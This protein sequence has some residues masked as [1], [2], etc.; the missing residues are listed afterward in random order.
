MAFWTIEK[1][2]Q[3]FLARIDKCGPNG[4]WL[5]TGGRNDGKRGSI[6]MEGRVVYAHRAAWLLFVGDIPKGMCVQ[7]SCANPL[8]VNYEQHLRIVPEAKR[9]RFV[10]KLE[11]ARRR[12]LAH[13]DKSDPDGCW[14]WT[15]ARNGEYGYTS[16]KGANTCAH[17]AA[18]LLFVG[19]IPDCY[20]VRHKCDNPICVNYERHLEIGTQ[21]Q[22]VEDM[23]ARGRR[24]PAR[25]QLGEMNGSSKLT[26]DQV[27]DILLSD[28]SHGYRL[29]LAAKH[30]VSKE[31]VSKIRAGDCW[32]HVAR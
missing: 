17:R 27:R 9:R 32:K 29:R 14:P 30:G 21:M 20:V 6:H 8:C 16:H 13:V 25:P 23:F 26:E 1:T 3:H 28:V 4:C 24:K 22:N 5:W 2:K 12:F 18:Y 11:T 31:M 15:G 19:E 7:Q 10:W